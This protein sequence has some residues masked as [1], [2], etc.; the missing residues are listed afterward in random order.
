MSD[1]S[2]FPIGINI[3]VIKNGNLLFGKRKGSGGEGMWGLPGGHLEMKENMVDAAARELKEE[4]SLECKDFLFTNVVNDNGPNN[5]RHYIQ[6]G[7]IAK[8]FSGEVKIMEPEYC[9]EWRWFSL[10]SL[11]ENI[12]FA[13]TKQVELFLK[14]QLFGDSAT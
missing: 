12:F 7:F 14:N 6:V 11:P 5:V 2:T 13:H 3:F 1:R 10:D 4:T 8:N 9:S